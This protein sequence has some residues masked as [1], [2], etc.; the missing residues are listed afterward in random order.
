MLALSHNAS[1]S[2]PGNTGLTGLW[3]YPTAEMPED[4]TGRFGYTHASPYSYFFIDLARSRMASM[5]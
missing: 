4:G 1:A 3:E 2:T 5:V